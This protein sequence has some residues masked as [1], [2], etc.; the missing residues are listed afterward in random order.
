M[1]V[2]V[3]GRG[4]TRRSPRPSLLDQARGRAVGAEEVVVELL[5]PRWP[6]AEAG[7]QAARLGLALDHRHLVARPASRY[8]SVNPSAP[9]P[10]TPVRRA[11][12]SPSPNPS[13]IVRNVLL[14]SLTALRRVSM[15][16]GHY[17]I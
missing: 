9:P 2:A 8:A 10:N 12:L 7:G 6:D 16:N 13:C 15:S 4:H 14:N 3:T 11:I 17:S 5:Q 1:S